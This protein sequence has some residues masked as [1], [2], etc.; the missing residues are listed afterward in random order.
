MY[1]TT[2]EYTLHFLDDVIGPTNLCESNYIDLTNTVEWG[3]LIEIG[4]EGTV[5]PESPTV[6]TFAYSYYVG[7]DGGT[8]ESLVQ[9]QSS[10]LA[11]PED[12]DEN[13]MSAY[14]PQDVCA[15]DSVFVGVANVDDSESIKIL[16][17][18]AICMKL[19][20]FQVSYTEVAM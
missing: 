2:Y 10:T 16:H 11:I 6:G 18:K 14:I 9:L 1:L 19:Q 12:C 17:A 15:L 8:Q 4:W 13:A 5:I 20:K 3:V 7:D